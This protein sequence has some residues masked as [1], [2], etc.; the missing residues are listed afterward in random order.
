M[1]EILVECYENIY[2]VEYT[3]LVHN[4]MLILEKFVY[5]TYP[6]SRPEYHK[7]PGIRGA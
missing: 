5:Q 6:V 1:R 4:T 3:L 7:S 2:N